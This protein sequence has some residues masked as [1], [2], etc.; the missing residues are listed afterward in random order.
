MEN[1]DDSLPRQKNDYSERSNEMTD[2]SSHGER[3]HAPQSLEAALKSE[4][5][6]ATL[7]ICESHGMTAVAPEYAS[8]FIGEYEEL[9]STERA[10]AALRSWSVV[11]WHLMNDCL[12]CEWRNE[13]PYSL[14]HWLATVAK[15]YEKPSYPPSKGIEV[16]SV[17]RRGF[18]SAFSK[19]FQRPDFVLE[20]GNG[21]KIEATELMRMVGQRLRSESIRSE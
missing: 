4:R 6:L 5:Y 8:D 12:K 17:G 3:V 16:Q 2:S 11:A 21:R 13:Y 14:C 18:S 19:A 20:D 1:D 15:H 9:N 7:Y 10:I